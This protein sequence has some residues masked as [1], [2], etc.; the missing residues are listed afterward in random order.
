MKTTTGKNTTRLVEIALLAGRK[1]TVRQ[2]NQDLSVNNSPEI[3]RRLREKMTIN[4]EWKVNP[5][6]GKRYGEYST[7]KQKKESRITK[8]YQ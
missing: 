8:L 4:T 2:M 7:P 6:N 3:I 5:L 1:L